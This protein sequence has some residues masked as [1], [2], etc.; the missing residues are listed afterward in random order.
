MS[1][2][3]LLKGM[4]G[5]DMPDDFSDEDIQDIGDVIDKYLKK[6]IK[7]D[8][9]NNFHKFITDNKDDKEIKDYVYDTTDDIDL[10]G[11]SDDL[12]PT[13]MDEKIRIYR[14]AVKLTEKLKEVDYDPI[15]AKLKGV[16]D[17][18]GSY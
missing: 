14:L 8:A 9:Y 5:E 16:K 4:L 1:L 7:D 12:D 13:I 11:L 6:E 10:D 2:Y 3:E 18:R 17:D 15:W